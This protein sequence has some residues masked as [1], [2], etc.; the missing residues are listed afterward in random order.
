SIDSAAG[1][2]AAVGVSAEDSAEAAAIVQRQARSM[3][4]LLDELL[5]VSRLKL[6]RLELKRER[7]PLSSIVATALETTRPLLADAG[8]SLTVQMPPK[9]V[10]VDCDP[11]RLGQ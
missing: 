5:D 4:A 2:I 9:E 3:K 8:H 10:Q 6:G 7:V 1:L 11:L